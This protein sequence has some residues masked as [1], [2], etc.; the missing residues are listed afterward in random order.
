M[1]YGQT[2]RTLTMTFI[3]DISQCCE[4]MTCETLEDTSLGMF[5]KIKVWY[6]LLL[7][8]QSYR[9]EQRAALDCSSVYFWETPSEIPSLVM[10][11]TIQNIIPVRKMYKKKFFLTTTKNLERFG[12]QKQIFDL[13]RVEKPKIIP[14]YSI[15][16]GFL[17]AMLYTFAT[18]EEIR[19]LEKKKY[20]L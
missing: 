17:L 18:L 1:Y 2:K 11:S 13:K 20:R 19:L 16:K 6:N 8:K 5:F 4:K 10:A 3:S 12:T 15:R 9:K 7:K 14:L